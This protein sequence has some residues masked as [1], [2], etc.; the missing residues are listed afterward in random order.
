[1]PGWITV[2]LVMMAGGLWVLANRQDPALEAILSGTLL[3]FAAIFVFYG[4][5]RLGTVVPM[6]QWIIFL[7][8]P[9]WPKP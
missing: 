9:L 5:T 3:G 4:L 1:M 2:V 6:K 7:A 8:I